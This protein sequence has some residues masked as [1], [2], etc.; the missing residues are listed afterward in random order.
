MLARL[1]LEPGS[2][3]AGPELARVREQRLAQLRRV[4]DEVERAQRGRGHDGRD[5]VR[6]QVR[7]RALSEPCDR[8]RATARVPARAAAERFAERA[9]QQIDAANDAAV[10]R[11]AAAARAH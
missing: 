1:E 5:A 2:L 3:H 8:G 4:L 6:E 11:S 7:T 10:L 9:R